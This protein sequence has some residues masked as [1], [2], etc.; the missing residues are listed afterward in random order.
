MFSGIIQKIAYVHKVHEEIGCKTY[1]IFL[2]TELLSNIKIG[3]SIANNGCCLT[4]IAIKK[5]LVSFNLIR[6]TLKLTN[7]HLLQKGDL[8]NIEEPVRYCSVIGGHLMTG[9]V[10]CT[11]EIKKII[12]LIKNNTIIWIN[13][14]NKFFKK[15]ILPQ[16]SIGIEGVSVTIN[17]VFDNNIRVCLTPYTLQKTTLGVK[18]IGNIV[19]IEFDFIIKAIVNNVEQVLLHTNLQNK[20]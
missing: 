2:P 3:S 8:V 14:K 15:Y 18:K 20:Y 17:R 7:M 5:N 13:I 11:G 10:D 12:N 16:G 19:N 1:S 6:A 4:V 9:H